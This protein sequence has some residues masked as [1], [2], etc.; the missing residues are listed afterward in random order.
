MP[1]R[2]PL[3]LPPTAPDLAVARA[4][5]RHATQ[6]LEKA[7]RV[8]TVLADEKLVLIAVAGVWAWC[9]LAQ[10]AAPA[11]RSS[12]QM[13]ANA[14][15]ASVVPHL[16]KR[17]IDRERPDRKV[18]GWRRHGIPRSGNRWDSFPS[19]HAVHVGALASALTRLAAPRWRSLI[20]TSAMALAATRLLLLA[21]YLTDVA[22]GIVL[23]ALIDRVVRKVAL[24]RT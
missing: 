9:H 6:P 10:Q 22:A 17:V 18:F 8:L 4:V 19:G 16:A 21:H 15:V 14:A 7:T 12:N 20:W 13:I 2:A 3:R 24:A 11:R 5:R 1:A 23:G